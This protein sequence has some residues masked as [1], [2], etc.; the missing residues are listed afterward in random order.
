M[1]KFNFTLV[2]LGAMLLTACGGGGSEGSAPVS[3][4]SGSS[5][6]STTTTTTTTTPTTTAPQVPQENGAGALLIDTDFTL[7]VDVTV[8]LDINPTVEQG[9]Y[10]T[11]CSYDP[12]YDRVNRQA[13][14]F[15]GPIGD[16][17]VR[18][19]VVL[20]HMDTELVAEI[21]QTVENYQPAQYRW[22]YEPSAVEQKFTVR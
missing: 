2:T 19:D 13:C 22:S 16:D 20:A 11:V 1:N 12:Q 3:A 10:L 8:S 18:E 15:R 21:W 5:Q 14:L 6:T 4:P 17:G 9:S 7:S